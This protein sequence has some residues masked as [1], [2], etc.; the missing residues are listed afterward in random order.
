MNLR[1]LSAVGD[2]HLLGGL[3]ALAAVTLDLLDDLHSLNDVAEH[4]VT[5]VQPGRLHRADEELRAV[6][7]GTGVGH[8]QGSGSG[9]LQGEVLVLELVAVDGLASGAV[10][11]GE[12]TA[13][14]HEVGDDAVEARSLEAEALLA[15]AQRTEVLDR[16][17]DDVAAELKGGEKVKKRI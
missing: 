9:V 17:G 6:G 4:D 1:Q 16:L 11:V 12:V 13:L 10:V 14:A 8:R 3:A 15:G 2:D 7:V 5:L